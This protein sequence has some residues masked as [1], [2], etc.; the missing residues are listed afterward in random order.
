VKKES[1]GNT[2]SVQ[3]IGTV[4]PKN[5]SKKFGCDPVCPR[6]IGTKPK[7]RR[8]VNGKQQLGQYHSTAS[9]GLLAG[10]L[11]VVIEDR[12]GYEGVTF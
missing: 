9:S 8:K 3:L 12:R 5:Y 10:R 6:H 1:H 11:R 7:L 4:T 2:W